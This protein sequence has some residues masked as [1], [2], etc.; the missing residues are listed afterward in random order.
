MD[1]LLLLNAPQLGRAFVTRDNIL[2]NTVPLNSYYDLLIYG[3]NGHKNF[4]LRLGLTDM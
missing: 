3:I 4:Y 1:L 2:F